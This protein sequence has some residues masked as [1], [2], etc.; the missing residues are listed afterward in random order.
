[1]LFLAG[2][3]QAK[4]GP[5]VGRIQEV[6]DMLEDQGVSRRFD[7]PPQM[8]NPPYQIAQSHSHTPMVFRMGLSRLF[9]PKALTFVDRIY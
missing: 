9:I 7:R 5:R 1:M 2:N 8:V 3:V 6:H 4:N